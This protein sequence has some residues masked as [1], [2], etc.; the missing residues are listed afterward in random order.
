MTN[1]ELQ[2]RL[3]T[4]EAEKKQL[5][6]EKAAAEKKLADEQAAAQQATSELKSLKQ[7]LAEE[8]AKTGP[9]TFSV[10][11]DGEE[12]EFE[13]TAPTL[14]WDDNS[15]IDVRNLANQAREI[16]ARIDQGDKVS[17]EDRAVFEK[18]QL[19][20]AT[21]VSRESGLVQRVRKEA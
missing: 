8:A 6:E 18:Y 5:A 20:C 10:E 1:E 11:E 4:L 9:V 13:F 14:T 7:T 15:V 21:L 17:K 19:I 16:V 12:V 2:A 3:A